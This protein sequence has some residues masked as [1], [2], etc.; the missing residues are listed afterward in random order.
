VA[1]PPS[2]VELP[3]SE[4]E[5]V[6]VVVEIP[7][8]SANKFEFDPGAQRFRLTRRLPV[9]MVYPSDYGFVPGTLSKDGDPLDALVLGRQATF[10]GCVIR[11]KPLGVLWTKDE[12]GRDPK[13]IGALHIDALEEG[14][15]DLDDI[16]D[17]VLREIE[18][19]FEVY[20][21]LEP[22]KHSEIDGFGG[23]Q[24][25]LDEIDKAAS[26]FRKTPLSAS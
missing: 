15:A 17:R 10:P 26:L 5:L 8:G 24:A 12:N 22:E 18:H 13:L 11:V 9:G 21:D 23:R 20:K 4:V 25:A 3:R 1:D 19:F 2:E 7:Q 14:L 6:D 16:P